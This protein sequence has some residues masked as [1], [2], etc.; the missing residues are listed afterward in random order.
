MLSLQS[1]ENTHKLE[2]LSLRYDGSLLCSR[3]TWYKFGGDVGDFFHVCDQRHT[4]EP[5]MAA[6][7]HAH[8]VLLD[9]VNGLLRE[10]PK[11]DAALKNYYAV[12]VAQVQTGQVAPHV[13]LMAVPASSMLQMIRDLS[14]SINAIDLLEPEE[15]FERHPQREDE[16]GLQRI[17]NIGNYR[18]LHTAFKTLKGKHPE[19]K[20]TQWFGVSILKTTGIKE[21]IMAAFKKT[22]DRKRVLSTSSLGTDADVEEFLNVFFESVS[23][24]P[25]FFETKQSDFAKEAAESMKE[26]TISEGSDEWAS[27]VWSSN[28]QAELERR[29]QARLQAAHVRLLKSEE[30]AKEYTRYLKESLASE[31]NV[32]DVRVT[33]G[34][35]VEIDNPKME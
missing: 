28:W 4:G 9:K 2:L 10:V 21:E 14:R 23:S 16:T 29:R 34:S 32:A 3:C 5:I 31:S 17:E 24:Q 33:E 35:S 26:R 1:I 13:G 6:I 22:M 7:S 8:Q 12:L 11:V 15:F 20:I 25:S 30:D 18:A 27:L 19:K